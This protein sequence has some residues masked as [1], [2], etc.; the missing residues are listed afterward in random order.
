MA[1]TNIDVINQ[2]LVLIGAEGISDLD[3][4]TTEA[5]VASSLYEEI[6]SECLTIHDWRF[7]LT[8]EA[9]GARLSPDPD[10]VYTARYN[11]PSDIIKVRTVYINDVVVDY[12]IYNG[13]IWCDAGTNDEPYCEGILRKSEQLW[14]AW[15]VTMVRHRLATDFAAAITGKVDMS[16]YQMQQF[17]KYLTI[18]RNRDSNQA[19]ADIANTKRF[20]LARR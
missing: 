7:A 20:I 14:P 13:E 12:R 18:A 6:I 9:L 2:A 19:P 16:D 5:E 11:V 15:F 4:G 1:R 10:Q 3:E 17:D 8:V